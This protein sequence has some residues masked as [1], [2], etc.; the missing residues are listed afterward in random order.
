MQSISGSA[1]SQATITFIKAF[2]N[3]NYSIAITGRGSSVDTNSTICES[4]G[5]RQ[6]GSTVV[7]RYG[8]SVTGCNWQAC[9]YIQNYITSKDMIKI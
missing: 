4:S 2:I 8:S 5:N 6:V 7:K 9:G 3:T 1:G